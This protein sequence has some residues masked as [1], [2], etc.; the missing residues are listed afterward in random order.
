MTLPVTEPLA[1]Y[2]DS[3]PYSMEVLGERARGG[4]TVWYRIRRMRKGWLTDAT[5]A[6]LARGLGITEDELLRITLGVPAAA[7]DHP[8]EGKPREL[9]DLCRAWP[10]LDEST[11]AMVLAVA[12][13]AVEKCAGHQIQGQTHS[14]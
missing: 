5:V 14:A 3:L 2:L 6:M 9:A 13:A 11:R 7:R 4:V 12:R 1:A 10:D 8:C